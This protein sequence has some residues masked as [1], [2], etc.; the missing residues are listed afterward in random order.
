M[1][2]LSEI[3]KKIAPYLMGLGFGTAIISFFVMVTVFKPGPGGRDICMIVG[4]SGFVVYVFGRIGLSMSR[5]EERRRAIA[6]S[7][8]DDDE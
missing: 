2:N 4:T 3:L 5:K 8:D 1:S 7:N 6:E